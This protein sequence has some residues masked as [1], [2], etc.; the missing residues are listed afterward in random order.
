[1]SRRE[2]ISRKKDPE[3]YVFVWGSSRGVEK[4]RSRANEIEEMINHAGPKSPLSFIGVIFLIFVKIKL[5]QSILSIMKYIDCQN[6]TLTPL[7]ST[8][9]KATPF[10]YG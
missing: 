5:I 4:E 7:N 10:Y 9:L 3:N 6:P 8:Q 1:M 2:R